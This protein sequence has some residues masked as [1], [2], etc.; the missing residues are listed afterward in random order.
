MQCA[1]VPKKDVD[2][3]LAQQR[4]FFA[5]LAK[6]DQADELDRLTGEGRNRTVLTDWLFPDSK[7]TD[8]SG[9]EW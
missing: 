1:G 6:P 9:G 2:L 4:A 7:T 8:R 5:F 3:A